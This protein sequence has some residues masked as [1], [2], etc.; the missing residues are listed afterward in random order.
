MSLTILNRF[1]IDFY[2][3][4]TGISL[5]INIH[6]R[7]FQVSLIFFDISVYY[8]TPAWRERVAKRYLQYQEEAVKYDL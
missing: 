8:L 7:G 2:W 4:F 1:D 6:K 5:G 3:Y